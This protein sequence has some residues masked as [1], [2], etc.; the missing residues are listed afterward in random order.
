MGSDSATHQVHRDAIPEGVRGSKRLLLRIYHGV[1]PHWL[2]PRNLARYQVLDASRG[3]IIS[4][5]FQG[6][7]YFMES[8]GYGSF[9]QILGTYELEIH[10]ALNRLATRPFLRIVDIGAGDGYYAVGLARQHD[11][12]VVHAFE[13]N[14]AMAPVIRELARMNGVAERIVT[15]GACTPESLAEAIGDP[16]EST[17]VFMDCDGCEA[18]VLD[19]SVVRSLQR[20]TIL[21][22]THGALVPGLKAELLRRFEPTHRI[23]RYPLR[24]RARAD[25][26]IRSRVL[27]RWLLSL[28]DEHRG[29]AYVRPEIDRQE[30]WLME[31]RGAG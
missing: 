26:P 22:E 7:R 12:A 17:L 14:E 27:D 2:R 16:P 13:A 1:V 10:E 31:P 28:T 4:G 5:P 18:Q 24:R 19:P 8:R 25:L 15:H 6:M 21:V 20:T 3:Q 9:A 29:M 23:T 30:W 11:S